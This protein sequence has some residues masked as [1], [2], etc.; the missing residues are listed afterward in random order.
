MG[1]KLC[2]CLPWGSG[3]LGTLC[4]GQLALL[5][6]VFFLCGVAPVSQTQPAELCL[7]KTVQIRGVQCNTPIIKYIYIHSHFSVPWLW[8]QLG[9]GQS[10]KGSSRNLGRNLKIF[11]PSSPSPWPCNRLRRGEER[12]NLRSWWLHVKRAR[13][14]ILDS[15]KHLSPP[16]SVTARSSPLS[17]LAQTLHLQVTWKHQ[18][19]ITLCF[20]ILLGTSAPREGGFGQGSD[21]G[22]GNLQCRHFYTSWA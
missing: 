21:P 4:M 17:C 10:I 22:S 16:I 11:I 18:C 13:S 1:G 12:G 9:I 20:G 7:G 19:L 15:I 6:M 5:I 3:Q 2:W 8:F 14:V